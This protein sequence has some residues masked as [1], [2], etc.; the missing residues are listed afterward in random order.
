MMVVQSRN[1]QIVPVSW[2]KITYTFMPSVLLGDGR[3]WAK[4][5]HLSTT[6]ILNDQRVSSE[7][8]VLELFG[9]TTCYL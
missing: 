5:R 4:I 6:G 9:G 8:F 1:R 3:N 7:T 2:A